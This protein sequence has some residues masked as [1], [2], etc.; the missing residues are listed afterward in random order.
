MN[1]AYATNY[2]DQHLELAKRF[3][4]KRGESLDAY[5][6]RLFRMSKSQGLSEA[7]ELVFLAIA[8]ATHVGG[9]VTP[10]RIMSMLASYG[11]AERMLE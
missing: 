2:D 8:V 11:S 1:Q 9:P 5:L 10:E 6:R 7:E 4:H 3:R